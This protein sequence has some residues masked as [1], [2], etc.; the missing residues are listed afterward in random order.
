MVSHEIWELFFSV[1]A[2]KSFILTVYFLTFLKKENLRELLAIK[3]LWLIFIAVVLFIDG[4]S[5]VYMWEQVKQ[6]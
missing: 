4:I 2:L 6:S 1:K 5:W 3:V